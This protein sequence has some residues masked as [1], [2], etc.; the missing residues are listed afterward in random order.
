MHNTV[1]SVAANYYGV[2]ATS[3]NI[4]C[5]VVDILLKVGN[6]LIISIHRIGY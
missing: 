6:L 4:G 1:A 5:V 2:V 3:I